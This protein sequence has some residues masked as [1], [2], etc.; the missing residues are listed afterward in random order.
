MCFVK[1]PVHILKQL[2]CVYLRRCI[3]RDLVMMP[4]YFSSFSKRFGWCFSDEAD[5]DNAPVVVEL[6]GVDSAEG[7]PADSEQQLTAVSLALS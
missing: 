7:Q 5:E 2:I 3:S 6:P 1:I 4:R